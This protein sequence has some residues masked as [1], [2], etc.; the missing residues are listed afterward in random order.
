MV[1]SSNDEVVYFFLIK[2]KVV[3]VLELSYLSNEEAIQKHKCS[4]D[5]S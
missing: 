3:Y 2:D 1:Q 5:T 4:I